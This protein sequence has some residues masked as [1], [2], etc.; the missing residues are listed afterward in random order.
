M[1]DLKPEI[2]TT[3]D[4]SVTLYRSDID[5]HYHS[6][7]GAVAESRHI[8][9]DMGW[10]YA[11]GDTDPLR[12][13]EVGYGTGLNAALTARAALDEKISTEYHS[14]ELYPLTEELIESLV[15]YQDPEYASDFR[16]VNRAPWGDSVRINDFFLLR[17]ME[18][19]LLTMSLPDRIDVVYFD[20]FGPEKQPEMWDEAVFRKLFGAMSPG[21]ILTTYCAKGSVRRLLQQIGFTTE[22]LPGPPGGKREIIRATKPSI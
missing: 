14:V 16:A 1:E 11:A 8:Y 20:A 9:L 22:R 15:A 10:R 21:G 7:K 6:V 3:A 18:S 12:V 19:D 5:E 4:G 17:K 2:Q 13:F